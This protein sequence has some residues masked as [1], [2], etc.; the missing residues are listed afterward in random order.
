MG[1]DCHL[2]LKEH[3]E[4]DS[5]NEAQKSRSIKS[6]A[7]LLKFKMPIPHLIISRNYLKRVT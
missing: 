2:L 3:L 1:R 6:A 5:Q 4:L 7:F